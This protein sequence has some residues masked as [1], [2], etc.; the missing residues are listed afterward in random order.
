MPAADPALALEMLLGSG[1]A[2][3]RRQSGR[4]RQPEDWPRYAAAIEAL[5]ERVA[6]FNVQLESGGLLAHVCAG[7]LPQARPI[8]LLQGAFRPDQS[9]SGSWQRWRGVAVALLA[10]VVLHGAGSW[11]QLHRPDAEVGTT[12][13]V[14]GQP[15]QFGLSRAATGCGSA[16]PVRTAPGADRR[17]LRPKRESCCRCWRPW[18][19]RSRTCRW[20]S[21]S[22]SPSSPG[23]MQ[24]RVGAPDANT[25]EQFSQALRAG[26]YGVEILSGQ[27]QGE[28]Y[29]RT[30]CREGAGLM[31]LDATHR[32]VR[33]ARAAR[34]AHPALGRRRGGASSCCC[35]S[36]CRCSGT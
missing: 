10:L 8:N 22:R 34:S 26:G 30:D 19:P 20:R 6:S 4:L 16:P 25:L 32:L 29:S 27:S 28:A 7:N 35:G 13:Q 18:R 14:H 5:R 9:R 2:A 21:W 36:C 33:Q 31:N 17:R 12:G 3:G 1:D 15:V 11:W 24:L 23:S